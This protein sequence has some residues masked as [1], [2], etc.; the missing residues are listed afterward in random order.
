VLFNRRF[1]HALRSGFIGEGRDF[2]QVG[3]TFQARQQLF[4][5]FA[6]VLVSYVT[7]SGF[8]FL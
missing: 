7:A 2:A 5:R 4:I 6:D 1:D 3:L 8:V